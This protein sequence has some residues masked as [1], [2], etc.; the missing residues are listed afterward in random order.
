M[1]YEIG[2]TY[3]TLT[4]LSALTTPILQPEPAYQGFQTV[5]KMSEGSGVGTGF[6]SAKWTW[7]V[8]TVA[9]RDMLKT[10]CTG[11]SATIYIRTRTTESANAFAAFRCKVFW[12]YPENN[13]NSI[14]YRNE[15]TLNFT[16]LELIPD[17][18]PEA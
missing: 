4:A 15:F 18:E 9:Q 14:R 7:P 16:E 1:P 8:L 6:P 17:P 5:E 10:F 11:A 2:S 13:P 12:P 3:E